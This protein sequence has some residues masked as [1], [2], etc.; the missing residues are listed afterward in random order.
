MEEERWDGGREGGREGGIRG[1]QLSQHSSFRE[2]GGVSG[3]P[4][5][6]SVRLLL[7]HFLS[8]SL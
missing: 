2:P 7:H 1:T 4:F 3:I 6:P 5:P 8:P